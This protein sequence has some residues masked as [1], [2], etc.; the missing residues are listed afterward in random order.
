MSTT[1]AA[2]ASGHK[3]SKI[4]LIESDLEI[5]VE[6]SNEPA[7]WG[8]VARLASVRSLELEKV[9]EDEYDLIVLDPLIPE[10]ELLAIMSAIRRRA[11]ATPAILFSCL[12]FTDTEPCDYPAGQVS[13]STMP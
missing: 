11:S 9:H 12:R 8:Q 1:V 3:L 2:P 6:T 4:L 7:E 5:A 13:E 10:P